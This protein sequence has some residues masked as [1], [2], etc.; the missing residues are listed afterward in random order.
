MLI[1]IYPNCSYSNHM[2]KKRVVVVHQTSKCNAESI[3]AMKKI[4]PKLG[5]YGIGIY[6]CLDAPTTDGKCRG[7]KGTYLLIDFYLGRNEEN[8]NLDKYTSYDSTIIT[9]FRGGVEYVVR[10]SNRALNFRYLKGDPPSYMYIEMRPR[11][12]LIFG[13]TRLKARDIISHQELPKENHPDIADLGYYLWPDIPSARQYGNN[14]KET[15]LIADVFFTNPFENKSYFPNRNDYMKYDSF[16]GAY[17]DTCY[18][19]VKYPQRIKNIHY[20]DG[21]RP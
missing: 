19:M 20:I 6:A 18:F 17:K 1:I 9:K 10:D 4:L 8:I 3:F 12:T 7:G 5:S 14:G 2:S 16:R 11:M 21:E 15:F 13:T